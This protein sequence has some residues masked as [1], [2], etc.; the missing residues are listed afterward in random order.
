MILR[1][2]SSCGGNEELM[3]AAVKRYHMIGLAGGESSGTH[4]HPRTVV[5]RSFFLGERERHQD[6][7]KENGF[8]KAIKMFLSESRPWLWG[9]R[10]LSRV[11][12][13]LEGQCCWPGSRLSA[14]LRPC[15]LICIASSAK[16]ISLM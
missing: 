10:S 13:E 3:T 9:F 7:D 6:A 4:G 16:A 12:S 14:A 15:C 1:Q 8:R 5:Q 11:C 2:A